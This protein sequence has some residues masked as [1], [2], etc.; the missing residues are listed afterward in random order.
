MKYFKIICVLSLMLPTSKLD[1]QDSII[2]KKASSLEEVN[3]SIRQ[4]LDKLESD[5]STQQRSVNIQ[6]QSPPTQ[7]ATVNEKRSLVRI[8]GGGEI[9]IITDEHGQVR[10][11]SYKKRS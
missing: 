6:L 10:R 1:A 7:T 3:K 5:T 9:V 2:F 8:P 4:A 11:T